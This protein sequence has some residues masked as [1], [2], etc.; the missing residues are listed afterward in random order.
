MK[1]G[2]RIEGYVVKYD[3]PNIG[4]VEVIEEGEIFDIKVKNAILG[5]KVAGTVNK[6]KHGLL[7]A[8]LE[9]VLEKAKEE[10]ADPCPHYRECGGCTYQTFPYEAQVKLKEKQ[11]LDL[12]KKALGE[13][14]TDIDNAL[15]RVIE[16]PDRAEYRNKMEFSFG[17]EYKDGPLA[18][19]MHKR[20]STYDVVNTFECRIVD[21]DFRRILKIT[22]EYFASLN[23]TYFHK[24]RHEG[25]LRHLCVRKGRKSGEIL[26]FLVTSTQWRKIYSKEEWDDILNTWKD[27]LL[28]IDTKGSFAGI[29]HVKNDCL[30]DA[31]KDEGTTILY[32]RDYFEE[33]L[34]GL[35]FK[36][37]SFSFFQNN[38]LAAECLY[39]KV[40]EY[41]LTD[42]KNKPVVYDLYTGTGT[43]AQLIAPAASRVI[44]VEIVEEAVE[45]AKISAKRNGIDNCTFLAGD[46]LKCLD[47]IETLPEYIILDPP[48]DGINPK[49]LEK[50][51]AYKVRRIVYVS[52]K[53]SSLARDLEAF[54]TN[55][56]KIKKICMTDLFPSTYHMEV[57]TL[58]ECTED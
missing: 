41:L 42:V 53:P 24:V 46:V 23:L 47:G 54:Y 20:G 17:D 43:I 30:A 19:G 3:F 45:A 36:I 56:Y 6:K 44:G 48:R 5:Q 27:K 15:E 11:I 33:E 10:T 55:G 13:N 21:E 49:A 2:D 16:S 37:S 14:S 8:R 4:H 28:S 52:C 58:L 26:V 38:S 18:L 40:R 12:L 7:E 31:V 51:L 25:V 29:L 39:S 22:K 35:R 1:K 34:L 9:E 57:V 50:I 32:G